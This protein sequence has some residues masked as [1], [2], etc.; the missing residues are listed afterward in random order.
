[1]I[2]KIPPQNIFLWSDNMKRSPRNKRFYSSL[3]L[4]TASIRCLGALEIR[5]TVWL[6][7]NISQIKFIFVSDFAVR[8]EIIFDVK[9]QHTNIQVVIKLK[10]SF[11]TIPEQILHTGSHQPCH[12]LSYS[13]LYTSSRR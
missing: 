1:M 7:V 5:M 3:R 6:Y 8:S 11:S 4:S 13:S 9:V 10:S 2:V 12:F